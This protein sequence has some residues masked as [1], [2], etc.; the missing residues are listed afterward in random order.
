MSQP[1][2]SLPT[3]F[4]ST[5]WTGLTDPRAWIVATAVTC[6]SASKE[7]E[8]SPFPQ[9]DQEAI[10]NEKVHPFAAM[11]LD[12]SLSGKQTSSSSIATARRGSASPMWALAVAT[13]LEIRSWRPVSRA[14][15]N[16]LG[17]GAEGLEP[18]ADVALSPTGRPRRE[19]W[20]TA[21]VF[22]AVNSEFW[23]SESNPFSE[24]HL[25]G[26]NTCSPLPPVKP[27]AEL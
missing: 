1:R 3:S 8:P 22:M 27:F 21:G 11:L 19:C 16:P 26:V 10:S 7:P 14:G 9:Q 4:H 23:R 12:T 18:T 5:L 24:H 6:P 17:C 15:V 20:R 2:V 25:S 13:A